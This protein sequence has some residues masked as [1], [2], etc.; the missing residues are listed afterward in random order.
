[1]NVRRGIRYPADPPTVDEI[2][3]VMRHTA[4]IAT[5]TARLRAMIVVQ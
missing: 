4:T 5:A 3:A 2:G 1:M